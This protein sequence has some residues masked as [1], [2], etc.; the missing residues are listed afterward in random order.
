[1]T[2]T[3]RRGVAALSAAVALGAAAPAVLATQANAATATTTTGPAAATNAGM[4]DGLFDGLLN[5]GAVTPSTPSLGIV[6]SLVTQ[7][8]ST[9]TA[10]GLPTSQ[11]TPVVTQLLSGGVPATPEAVGN[12]LDDIVGA[13]GSQQD[14]TG[15]ISG[16]LAQGLSAGA[17]APLI[18]DV[19]GTV[20][21]AGLTDPT[22]IVSAVVGQLLAVGLPTN[23][24]GLDAAGL[25]NLLALLNTGADPTGL[26]LEPVAKLLDTVGGNSAL[27]LD[28]TSALLGLTTS[29]RS[30][31][32]GVVPQDLLGQISG[33][34]TSLTGTATLTKP[35]SDA[36]SGL[37]GLLLKPVAKSGT[38][39]VPP[40]L[41]PLAPPP[42]VAPVKK[43]P[44]LSLKDLTAVLSSLK[45]DKARSV[46]TAT[47]KCP[48]T[49]PIGC[50]VKSA[51]TLDGLKSGR[52]AAMTLKPGVS[53]T[54]KLKLP[55]TGAHK[56][57]RKGGKVSV[58]ATTSYAGYKL[59][60]ASKAMRVAKVKK[61]A[62]KA[63]KH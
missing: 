12:L 41:T 25:T 52:A 62:K 53:K 13:A 60:T 26:L 28:V 40:T 18:D 54:L 20:G 33:L 38:P 31:G 61:A 10:V 7:L 11:L 6:S 48:A 21:G 2:T 63:H 51:T 42:T 8:T 5:L 24:A 44:T 39:V 45:V 19:L 56:L 22:S 55:A 43:K 23:A 49:S 50:V 57:R 46:V 29:I 15:L 36:L 3:T 14:L 9:A 4:A 30:A 1:M 27:P 16:L 32:T 37:A 59:G 47:L 34:L 17:I 58:K 35:V